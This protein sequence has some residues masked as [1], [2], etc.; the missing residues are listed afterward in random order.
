MY[1]ALRT[2]FEVTVTW[3]GLLWFPS[4]QLTKL[5]LTPCDV[6]IPGSIW[7]VIVPVGTLAW[8]W[9]EV[10][11]YFSPLISTQTFPAEVMLSGRLIVSVGPTLNVKV[12]TLLSWFVLLIVWPGSMIILNS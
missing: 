1:N 12:A 2:V 4:D 11:L 6:L 8:N 9:L 10:M 5:C 7:M 3:R